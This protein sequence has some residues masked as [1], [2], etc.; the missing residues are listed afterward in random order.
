MTTRKKKLQ[1]FDTSRFLAS[2]ETIEAYLSEALESNDPAFIAHA[3]GQVAK[4]KGM[5][6]VAKKTG[7]GRESLYKALSGERMTEFGTILLVLAALGYT[8]QLK[9]VSKKVA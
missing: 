4:A 1:P 9:H 8:L 7:L 3:I 2:P 5:T 6:K